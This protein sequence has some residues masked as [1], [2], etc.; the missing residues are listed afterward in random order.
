MTVAEHVFILPDGNGRWMRDRFRRGEYLTRAQVYRRGADVGLDLALHVASERRAPSPHLSICVSTADNLRLRDPDELAQIHGS[1]RRVHERLPQLLSAGVCVRVFG[2]VHALDDELSSSLVSA[3]DATRRLP[4][5]TLNLLVGWDPDV[6][7]KERLLGEVSVHNACLGGSRSAGLGDA[8]EVTLLIRT[9]CE[10]DAWRGGQRL[11][12]MPARRAEL[13][14]TET[15]WP[16]FGPAELD[17]ARARQPTEPRPSGGRTRSERL[18]LDVMER[19]PRLEERLRRHGLHVLPAARAE[20]LPQASWPRRYMTEGLLS[21]S[22]LFRY[23]LSSAFLADC[24]VF[25]RPGDV[26]AQMEW[27]MV[28]LICIDNLFDQDTF[29]VEELSSICAR[30]REPPLREAEE[31]SWCPQQA[32]SALL[33]ELF[34][35]PSE[36][37][38]WE[39]FKSSII[40]PEGVIIHMLRQQQPEPDPD[41]Y[42][43]CSFRSIAASPLLWLGLAFADEAPSTSEL[44]NWAELADA[45]D[46]TLRMANDLRTV[47]A[48]REEGGRCCN[49][50]LR[51]EAAGE[52]D[53]A[54]RTLVQ[55]LAAERSLRE[56]LTRL[57]AAPQ[58]MEI[59]ARILFIGVGVY[60]DAGGYHAKRDE[61]L[62]A[63]VDSFEVEAYLR[64]GRDGCLSGRAGTQRH[65]GLASPPPHVR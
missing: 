53:V 48:E 50:L 36:G 21:G 1:L 7:L 9:G 16:D 45:L 3:V 5:L 42:F 39:R 63:L 17:R 51:R 26:L 43:E 13:F 58:L 30:L 60:L 35:L 15:L 49:L 8:P 56:A 47:D 38:P 32:A 27:Y 12:G 44:V 14:F 2:A 41:R 40:G 54:A 52:S 34:E 59:A 20:A 55:L 28:T 61:E 10:H 23:S 4:W 37:A 25:D 6:F 46:R 29:C 24:P 18:V 11:N 62:R 64:G 22:A 31:E 19:F 65:L 33:A 57:D